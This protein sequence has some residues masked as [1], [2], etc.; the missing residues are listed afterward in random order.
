MDGEIAEDINESVDNFDVLRFVDEVAS[1][2]VEYVIFT[3]WHART[4]ALYPSKVTKKG[5]RTNSFI[6][7]WWVKS[8]TVCGSEA[9]A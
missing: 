9:S 5:G 6:E 1:M 4:I 3:A 7:T 2:R 8:S